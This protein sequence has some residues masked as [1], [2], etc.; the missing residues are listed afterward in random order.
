M[1][2]I[3]EFCLRSPDLPLA[4]TLADVP[5]A[6]LEL[7]TEVGTDPERPYLFFWQCGVDPETFEAALGADPTVGSVERYDDTNDRVLYRVQVGEGADVVTYPR[8]V[9]LGLNP[10]TARWRDGWWH[11]RTRFPDRE[12]LVRVEALCEEE[13]LEFRLD[14]VHAEEADRGDGAGLTDEQRQVLWTAH[15]LGYFEIPRAASLADVADELDV[16]SQAV[17]ERLRRG[18]RSLVAEH[19][20]EERAPV[21]K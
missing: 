9:E 5:E 18:F 6:S 1:S 17:S 12:T 8:W 14:S 11:L 13:G 21:E 20:R 7:V 15:E 3:V 19:V 16:S 10:I 2:P 4:P